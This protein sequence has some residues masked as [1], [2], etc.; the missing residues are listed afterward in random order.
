MKKQKLPKL[1]L[2]KETLRPLQDGTIGQVAGGSYSYT[3]DL[4][5]PGSCAICVLK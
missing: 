1:Q 2:S 4:W 3:I 5:P